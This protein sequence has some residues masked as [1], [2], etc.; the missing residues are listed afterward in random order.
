MHK[1]GVVFGNIN[2]Q[3]TV[4]QQ[5]GFVYFVHSCIVPAQD[6]ILFLV[7]QLDIGIC[8][9]VTGFSLIIK[10]V[11]GKGLGAVFNAGILFQQG[12]I[13]LRIVPAS[14]AINGVAV[15]DD[16]GRPNKI[17]RIG[18][19]IVLKGIGIDRVFGIFNHNTIPELVHVLA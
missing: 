12:N 2:H 8:F 11:S 5:G 13:C 18:D 17:G 6:D 15:A 19:G 14:L 9:T 4:C 16:T 10:A 3:C 7:H 1:N